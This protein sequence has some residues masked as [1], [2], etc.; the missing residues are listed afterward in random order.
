MKAQAKSQAAHIA[1][2]VRA[3]GWSTVILLV[4]LSCG[5]NGLAAAELAA[6]EYKIAA[7]LMGGSVPVIVLLLSTISGQVWQL[8][9]LLDGAWY[10]N[11]LTYWTWLGGGAT[12][13]LLYLSISHCAHSIEHLT[14]CT[15]EE[16]YPMAT[17]IDLGLVF[18]KGAVMFT[19]EYLAVAKPATKRKTS[20][21]KAK[22]AA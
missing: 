19:H 7:W 2:Q 16:A 4:L 9:R 11:H 18:A 17:A 8:S 15:P 21:R 10:A 3:W 20:S 14:G 12:L 5:L 13:W 6:E 22:K 1:A